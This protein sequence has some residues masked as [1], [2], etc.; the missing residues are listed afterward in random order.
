VD[1]QSGRLPR[2]AA[3]FVESE[4]VFAADNPLRMTA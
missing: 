4:A 1:W 2:L 3:T